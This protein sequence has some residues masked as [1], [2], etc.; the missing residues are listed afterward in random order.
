VQHTVPPQFVQGDDVRVIV[1]PEDEIVLVESGVARQAVQGQP[2]PDAQ[3]A[4][5]G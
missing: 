2:E 3:Q 1:P 4:E 5:G